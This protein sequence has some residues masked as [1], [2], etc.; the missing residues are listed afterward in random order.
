MNDIFDALNRKHPAEGVRKN[1]ND[2][3]VS[4]MLCVLVECLCV[5]Y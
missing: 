1:N 2:L 3:E 5:T 4:Y